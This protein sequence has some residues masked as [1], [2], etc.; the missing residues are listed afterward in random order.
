MTS[1]QILS[2]LKAM[3]SDSIKRIFLNHGAK[4]PLFGVKVQ[5]L[6]KIQKKVKKNYELALELYNTGNSDAQYLAGLIADEK[7]MTK[8]DLETWAENARWYMQS[9]YTVP[10]IAS[11]SAHGYELALEWIDSPKEH[12]QI[13]G[14]STLS[15]LASIKQDENLDLGTYK[16]LLHR[17]E[18]DI[19]KAPNRIRYV[20]NGFVISVGCFITLLTAE[21][22]KAGKAIGTVKVEMGGTS[23]KVPNAVQYIQKAMAKGNL[24]KKK[25]MAR[26]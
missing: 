14:W 23:C 6:K 24:G 25:K 11:E 2:E 3:G 22:L 20:M 4:E 10:W 18:K 12:L 17:V 8:K 13:A 19:H 15:S 5:D 9:E 21:A 26:C 1:Q 7:K 16:S